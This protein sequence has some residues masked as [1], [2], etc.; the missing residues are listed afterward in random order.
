M[1]IYCAVK[2]NIPEKNF[3][4]QN[5]GNQK[6]YFQDE[7]EDDP[8]NTF[9]QCEVCFGNIERSWVE[10]S[11]TLQWL[12]LISVGIEPY[13]EIGNKKVHI[14]NL[15]GFFSVPV[16]ESAISGLLSLF[17]STGKLTLLKEQKTWKGAE[18]RPS[19]RTLAGSKVLILGAGD[20]GMQ[21]HKLLTVFGC[22]VQFFDKFSPL[23]QFSQK[24]ELKTLFPT[25]DIVVGCL[26]ENSETKNLLGEALL[27]RLKHQAIVV[28]VGRGS[29]IDE[30]VLVQK[31]K[32][33]TL[34]G[35]VLDVTCEEPLPSHSPLWDCPNLVLSQHTAGGS[36]MELMDKIKVFH[37]NYALFVNGMKLKNLI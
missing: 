3:L 12:Q 23:A 9:L 11:E 30:D 29:L 6:V 10:Q 21:I 25:V 8:F 20:I 13:L 18:L 14:T 24:E 2:L 34:A 5:T 33:G 4:K 27:N 17:R 19:M 22:N 35:A 7:L 32:N 37:E 15:K 36:D 31:L 28:N 1:K 26:P 16:A